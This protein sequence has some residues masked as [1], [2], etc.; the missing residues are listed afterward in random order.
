MLNPYKARVNRRE[1]LNLP[2]FHDGAYVVA[3][4]EDTS[5]RELGKRSY[6]RNPQPRM[7]LEISDCDRRIN[8]EF[9]LATA[10]QRMN[11]FHKV[12][13]LIEVLKE[14]R[15]GLAYEC[16]QVKRRDGDLKV[17]E[18]AEA[19]V[20]A[21]TATPAQSALVAAWKEASQGS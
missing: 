7:I 15:T 21:K 4:V 18:E 10:V 2:G 1:F 14:F 9:E 17:L 3:Y 11:S 20:K 8:L 5:E 13:T 6:E 19:A 12:D 16:H